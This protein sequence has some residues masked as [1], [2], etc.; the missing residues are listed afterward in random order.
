MLQIL[1][2]PGRFN[3]F[4]KKYTN[5]LR[6]IT[7][8]LLVIG[9]LYA[10]VFSPN[11]YQQGFSVKIMYIHVPCAWLAMFTY[12]LMTIY[13][14]LALSFKITF[15]YIFVK[16]AA[17][18][19]AIFTLIC[20]I[21]GSIWGKPMWGTW[22]VWDARLTSVLI[23][24]IFYIIIIIIQNT[25][26]DLQIGEKISSIFVLLGSI[27]L[28]VI[29]YSVDWW[30]TLHQPA[31][32]SKLSSPSIEITILGPLIAMNVAMTFLFFLILFIRLGAEINIRKTLIKD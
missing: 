9:L 18:I 23:L 11:D 32:V 13:S 15:G 12:V 7:I 14:I 19:G 17:P 28:P 10:L 20:L 26:D 6:H 27:N 16:A 8:Y 2:N 24:F 22:W 25:F 4:A 3:D 5:I 30:N 1:Y 31:S 29:K 21:S